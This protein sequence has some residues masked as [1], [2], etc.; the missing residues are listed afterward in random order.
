VAFFRQ[1]V[2]MS[3][4]EQVDESVFRHAALDGFRGGGERLLLPF[5]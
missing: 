5:E 4:A 2:R 1:H 3:R